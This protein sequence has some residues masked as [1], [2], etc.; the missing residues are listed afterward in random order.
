[1]RIRN[2]IAAVGVGVVA[3]MG[4]SGAVLPAAAAPSQVGPLASCPDN[5]WSIQ[6]G[7]SGSTT[8]NSVNIRSGPSTS[9]TALGQAQASHS[10]RYDCYKVEGSYTWTHIYDRTTGYSGW[11]RDDLLVGYGAYY[12]C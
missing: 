8:G 10:L 12:P 1:M 9:C 7:R 4:M 5:S 6:D 11:I 3:L 2:K